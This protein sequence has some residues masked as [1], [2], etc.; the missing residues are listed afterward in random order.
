MG[1]QLL[2]HKVIDYLLW[3][4][5]KIAIKELVSGE[6]FV[7]VYSQDSSV[8]FIRKL[9]KNFGDFPIIFEETLQDPTFIE[10]NT[11]ALELIISFPKQNFE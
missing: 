6:I 3:H 11:E 2:K 1:S 4:S 7:K 9:L 5:E 8:N 10:D